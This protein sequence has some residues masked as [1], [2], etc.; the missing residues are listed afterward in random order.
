V[1]NRSGALNRS[2]DPARF[3]RPAPSEAIR[4]ARGCG[5]RARAPAESLITIAPSRAE[6]PEI[7]SRRASQRVDFT[8]DEIRDGFFKIAFGA[9]LRTDAKAKRV[10]KFDEPVRIFVAGSTRSDRKAVI[11]DVVADIA[12]RINGLDVALAADRDT[13][14]LSI[15]LANLS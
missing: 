9:E 8:D 1:G 10:R 2:G 6:S 14:N 13:A 5:I 7:T 4:E 15:H 11:A 3:L 12:A